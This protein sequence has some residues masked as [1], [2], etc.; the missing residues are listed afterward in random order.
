MFARHL[1]AATFVIVAAVTTVSSAGAELP[2]LDKSPADIAYFRKS[3][4]DAPLAK[5]IYS[6]PQKHGR[7]IF[8]GLVP[9]GEV[10][11]TGANE[12][13]EI[14]FFRDVTFGG[15][16]VKAG[17][18]SLFTIPREKSWT[19]ILSSALDEWGAFTYDPKKDVVRV[20]VPVGE[21][22]GEVDAFTM[23]FIGEPPAGR[24]VFAW[25]NVWVEVPLSF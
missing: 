11:R 12:A 25:D 10:W 23:T 24:L 15:K 7:V 19:I 21:T 22:K 4:A 18:Y 1:L 8:G 2:G 16:R 9:Y 13:T 5:L 17:R 14:D 6:R 20:D 3:R